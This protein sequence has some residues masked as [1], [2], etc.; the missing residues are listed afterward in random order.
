VVELDR[1]HHGA[2]RRKGDGQRAEPRS[3]LHHAIRW[4]DPGVA[5]DRAG[6]VR[7]DQEML[8]EGLRGTDAVPGRELPEGPG[9]QALT[10]RCA[11]R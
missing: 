5:R 9:A 4:T 2:G 6:E 3:Q 11:T 8:P 1:E 7:I 10:H